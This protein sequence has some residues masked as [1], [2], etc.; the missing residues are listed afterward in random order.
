MIDAI[1]SLARRVPAWLVYLAGLVPPVWLFV[2]ALNG[3]LGVDPVKAL[4]HEM[5]KL[6]LQLII[7]GLCI[8]PLRRFVGLSLIKFRRAIGLVAF[9]YIVL[10]FATWL[11]LDMGLRLDE[12]LHDILRRPYVTAGMVG[13]AGLI[14]LAITSNNWSVRRLGPVRWQK[15][16]WLTYVVALAGGIHYVWL[17]KTWT[18]E[19]LMYLAVILGLLALRIVKIRKRMHAAA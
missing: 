3:Q 7:A 19:S 8:S 2:L 11:A 10:H 12:A 13:L 14:P 16:H 6:G 18:L 5:G 1:N 4:E 15:L 9:F 17:V